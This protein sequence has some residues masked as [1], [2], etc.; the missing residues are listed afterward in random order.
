MNDFWQT[1]IAEHDH[2]LVLSLLASG[3]CLDDARDVAQEAWLKL[4][5]AQVAGRLESV[6]LPGLVIRQASFLV[7][8]R[9]RARKLRDHSDLRAADHLHGPNVASHESEATE[10]LERLEAGLVFASARERGVLRAVIESPGVGH[11]FLAAREG[12][13]VQRFRQ[14]LSDVRARLRRFLE[15]P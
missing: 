13:S 2:A 5:E 12:V 4:I 10:L 6:S 1:A 7:I 8:D 11:R 9:H 3:L 14:V 15:A